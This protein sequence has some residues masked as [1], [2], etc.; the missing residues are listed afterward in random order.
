MSSSIS[1]MMLDKSQPYGIKNLPDPWVQRL[2][3]NAI[4]DNTIGDDSE[5]I[6]DLI[7]SQSFMEKQ[8]MSGIRDLMTIREF[9]QAVQ[10]VEINYDNIHYY[11]DLTR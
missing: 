8:Q 9:N 3:A 7:R 2:K 4:P 1:N 11:Y 6:L 5:I 10:E